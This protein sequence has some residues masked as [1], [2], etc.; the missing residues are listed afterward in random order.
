MLYGEA[1]CLQNMELSLW[2][3]DFGGPSGALLGGC[4]MVGGNKELYEEHL[5]LFHDLAVPSGVMFL[6][7]GAG[8]LQRWSTMVLS[9]G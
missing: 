3:W 7:S 6:R 4:L 8:H 1:Q 9:T 5:R 2:M